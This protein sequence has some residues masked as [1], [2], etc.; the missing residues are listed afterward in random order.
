MAR[1]N[2]D[3]VLRKRRGEN[4]GR[5]A[6]SSS[7]RSRQ[8]S[9]DTCASLDLFT[10]RSMTS[11]SASEESISFSAGGGGEIGSFSTLVRADESNYGGIADD[12]Q[13]SVRG[14]KLPHP[15]ADLDVFAA[16]NELAATSANAEPSLVLFFQ[17]CSLPK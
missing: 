3:D 5:Q 16:A 9:K 6:L 17:V 14:A 2:D 10:K 11:A 8:L 4:A 13:A 7:S 15:H 12:V 1:L